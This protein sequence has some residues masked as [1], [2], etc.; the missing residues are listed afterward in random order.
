MILMLE[1]L[2]KKSIHFSIDIKKNI[3]LLIQPVETT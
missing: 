2:N 1:D 3:S